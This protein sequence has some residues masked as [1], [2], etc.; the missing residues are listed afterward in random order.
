[1]FALAIGREDQETDQ[2][3]SGTQ[4][5]ASHN[6]VH[7][8]TPVTTRCFSRANSTRHSGRL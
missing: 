8:Q 4:M 1:M 7:F 2:R 5:M 6:R 3:P